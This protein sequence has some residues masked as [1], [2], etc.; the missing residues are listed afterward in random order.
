MRLSPLAALR[1]TTNLASAANRS[2]SA[3]Y[4][5]GLTGGRANGR[6][7]GRSSPME[8]A[9]GGLCGRMV[10]RSARP[11]MW[12]G[13]SC[14][15]GR[16]RANAWRAPHKLAASQP[17]LANLWAPRL[18]EV[19]LLHTT[20]SVEISPEVGRSRPKLGHCRAS[21]TEFGPNSFQPC[22]KPGPLISPWS[23][24]RANIGAWQSSTSLAKCWP[25][26][27]EIDKQMP[28]IVNAGQSLVRFGPSW[29]ILADLAN[30][31]PK[32]GQIWPSS[33]HLGLNRPSLVETGPNLGSP[34]N[35]F[36]NCLAPVRQPFGNCNL[37]VT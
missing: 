21:S 20:Q 19:F 13:F 5:S 9:L 11:G 10:G 6:A 32:F 36:C 29:Q 3:S 2:K 27:T 15:I 23:M 28:T 33:T 18:V 4:Q 17:T 8:R 30:F 35:L 31:G 16:H 24:L 22:H 7:V 12:N 25:N 26:L 14:N 34:S 1:T 37:R